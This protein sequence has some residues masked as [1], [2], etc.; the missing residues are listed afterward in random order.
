MI[1]KYILAIIAIVL[2]VWIGFF[3][4]KKSAEAP[5]PPVSNGAIVDD[6]PV[7]PSM[8]EAPV[9]PV[10]TPKAITTAPKT[11]V[12]TT[13]PAM[14]KDGSYIVYYTDRGF[15]P[16]TITIKPG[17][18]IHFVNSS[19]KA[20]S[21][22]TTEPNDQVRGEFNQGKTVGKGGV[23]DFTF[24]KEGLWQYMNRNNS[25]DKGMIVVK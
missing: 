21:V 16:S 20:M 19:N 24:L 25:A 11:V 2:A 18:S 3:F 23:Y 15:S 4:G 6:A 9:A 13:A 22:A 5:E 12:K 10:M 8:Q 17:K 7:A 14:T 1:K